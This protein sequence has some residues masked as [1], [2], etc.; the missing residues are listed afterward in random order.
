MGIVHSENK[1]LHVC[2]EI[3]LVMVVPCFDIRRDTI[4][5]NLDIDGSLLVPLR[6]VFEE[7]QCA[8]KLYCGIPI[9]K[10]PQGWANIEWNIAQTGINVTCPEECYAYNR[11]I[12]V[13]LPDLVVNILTLIG[14]VNDITTNG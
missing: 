1:P 12:L 10:K 4:Q 9:L 5:D 3:I 14:L 8:L 11:K 2:F 7:R 13:R 6:W